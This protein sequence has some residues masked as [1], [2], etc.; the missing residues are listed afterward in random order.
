[1]EGADAVFASSEEASGSLVASLLDGTVL[2]PV[3]HRGQV[4]AASVAARKE[5]VTKE[6]AAVG[7][8]KV[9]APEKLIKRLERIE[10]CGI[11]LSIPPQQIGCLVPVLR[12]VH[13]HPP[14]AVRAEAAGALQRL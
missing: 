2:D 14:R 7:R 5:K 12:R 6:K 4:G 9:N 3:T 1:M 8:M 13:E 11:W 10:Q